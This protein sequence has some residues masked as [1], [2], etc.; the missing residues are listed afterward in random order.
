M[1]R[2]ACVPL[3]GLALLLGYLAPPTGTADAQQRGRREDRATDVQPSASRPSEAGAR[4]LLRCEATTFRL[5]LPAAQ[6]ASLDARP[7]ATQGPTAEKLAEALGK[8]G[9]SALLLHCDQPL[10]TGQSSQVDLAR[11]VPYVTGRGAASGPQMPGTAV[12]RQRVGWTLNLQANAAD[13]GDSGRVNIEMSLDLSF[14]NPS[15]VEVDSDVLAPI[16]ARAEQKYSGLAALGQPL[17]LI[18]ADG[19]PNAAP[20][21]GTAIITLLKLSAP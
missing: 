17:I 18:S 7:L 21:E 2:I 12:S 11:D 13:P 14:M 8:L 6:I 20:D 5:D 10:T 15:T 1:P 16:F 9:R 3:A 19:G 4:T